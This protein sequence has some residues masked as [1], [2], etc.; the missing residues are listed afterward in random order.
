MF[1]M[2]AFFILVLK[3][4][5]S[6]LRSFSTT[7]VLLGDE[8]HLAHAGINISEVIASKILTH[9]DTEHHQH[10]HRCEYCPFSHVL[11]WWQKS[12]TQANS[13]A[14]FSSLICKS[15]TF[16]GAAVGCNVCLYVSKCVCFEYRS[17]K[18]T[19]CM[20]VCVCFTYWWWVMIYSSRDIQT[21]L[22]DGHSD[23]VI[24]CVSA[25]VDLCVCRKPKETF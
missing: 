19:V 6:V 23:D 21:R 25:P 4:T 22:E 15:F 12:D 18:V 13:T 8:R 17:V 14:S 10:T 11:H 1:F 2:F 20:C 3:N 16:T 24:V 7:L 9:T 5:D